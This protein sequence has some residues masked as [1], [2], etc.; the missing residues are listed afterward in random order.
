M[1]VYFLDWIWLSCWEFSLDLC[2]QVPMWCTAFHLLG[3]SCWHC[4]L[5]ILEIRYISTVELFQGK[6]YHICCCITFEVWLPKPYKNLFQCCSLLMSQELR[7]QSRTILLYHPRKWGCYREKCPC[8][9]HLY[10][11]C[12]KD[13][14]KFASWFR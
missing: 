11:E 2:A 9:S 10:Y 8:G 3:C 7:F 1:I 13:Q 6:I 14:D 5:R 4:R 12:T